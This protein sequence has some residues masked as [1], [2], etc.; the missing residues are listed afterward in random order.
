M[1]HP[2][3][4]RGGVLALPFRIELAESPAEV[5]A[6]IAFE[7]DEDEQITSDGYTIRD[8]DDALEQLETLTFGGAESVDKRN[9]ESTLRRFTRTGG[10]REE[11]ARMLVNKEP[12]LNPIVSELQRDGFFSK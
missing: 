9:V 10:I 3:P 1:L 4:R 2:R 6:D 12:D 11:A 5:R 8:L 7:L